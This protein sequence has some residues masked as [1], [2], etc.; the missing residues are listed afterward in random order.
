MNSKNIN[1]T[2]GLVC[3]ERTESI[4]FTNHEFLILV[5]IFHKINTE[6]K[7]Y[8]EEMRSKCTFSFSSFNGEYTVF[9]DL[10]KKLYEINLLKARR[11]LDALQ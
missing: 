7:E 8:D 4:Q 5:D 6:M 1:S 2:E 9:R 3:P 10:V 11:S